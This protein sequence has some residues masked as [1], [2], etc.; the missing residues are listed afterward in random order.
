MLAL[1]L[2]ISLTV[3]IVTI[4]LWVSAAALHSRLTTQLQD[5]TQ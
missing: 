1:I 2:A 5:R 3:G 4:P